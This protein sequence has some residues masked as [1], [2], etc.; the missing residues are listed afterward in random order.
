MVKRVGAELEKVDLRTRANAAK[1]PELQAFEEQILVSSARLS[2]LRLELEEVEARL[3]QAQQAAGTVQESIPLPLTSEQIYEKVEAEALPVLHLITEGGIASAR[4]IS[5]ANPGG[6]HAGLLLEKQPRGGTRSSA[7]GNPAGKS[8]TLFPR[9][10]R[11]WCTNV[12]PCWLR[13]SST[14]RRKSKPTGESG[15]G[16]Q[17]E[18]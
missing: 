14:F 18:I 1:E 5:G 15:R 11:A 16:A 12:T 9:P 7:R 4:S 6:H 10:C 17:G 2:A 8:M 3:A 13:S